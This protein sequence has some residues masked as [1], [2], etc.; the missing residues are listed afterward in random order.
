MGCLERHC[1][2]RFKSRLGPP[3]KAG[4]GSGASSAPRSFLLSL[5]E[6]PGS[7][8][9]WGIFT[10]RAQHGDLALNILQKL[11]IPI[12]IC[13]VHLSIA[14]A[15]H[16]LERIGEAEQHL[17]QA[18]R[19]ANKMGSRMLRFSALLLKATL[20]LDRGEKASPLTDIRHAL[21]LGRKNGF[22]NS[23]IGSARDMA[24]ICAEA[25]EARIEVKYVREDHS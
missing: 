3:W 17:G 14:Q 4:V 24:R 12:N 18:F 13:I 2:Q 20:A 8:R 6:V 19:L 7:H 10:R 16:G 23:L 9:P 15:M 1:K 25:L 22:F 11:G 5:F 21:T